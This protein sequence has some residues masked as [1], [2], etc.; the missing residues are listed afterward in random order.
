MTPRE[1]ISKARKDFV[2]THPFL[3]ELC[4]NLKVVE[5]TEL[6]STMGTDMACLYYN[7]EAV[8]A[9]DDMQLK[10]VIAHE[11]GH[12]VWR[13]AGKEG[14]ARMENKVHGVWSLACEY[15]ANNFVQDMC[16]LV[17]PKGAPYSS[18]YSNGKWTTE[19]IYHDILPHYKTI[20]VPAS[21]MDDHSMWG[22]G[23][24]SAAA[25]TES[26]WK[27]HVSRVFH[28]AK[29]KGKMPAGL[30]RIVEDVLEPE[31]PWRMVL[32]E[33]V[34]RTFKSDY[35]WRKPNKRHLWRKMVFPSIHSESIR[36]GYAQDT[37]GSMSNEELK[38]GYAE[39][40]GICIAFPSYEIH[41]F[42]CDAA[43]HSYQ[44]STPDKPVDLAELSKGGGGTD[45]RPV[46][47]Y[48]EEH[49]IDIDALVYFTDGEGTF[50]RNAPDYP[51]IWVI[52]GTANPPFGK[53]LRY[54]D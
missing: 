35:S 40:R 29:R 22:K 46:F 41:L 10:A 45:F 3:G 32:A 2:M 20:S 15:K 19:G 14:A 7:P 12:C 17:L 36:I 33:V 34:M 18:R 43:V 4:L 11:V 16:G 24:A 42:A 9:W 39:I 50:P 51:V 21:F 37:S 49:E 26:S 28:N 54:E 6:V 13:H 38:E 52:K 27:V 30:E 47:K 1:R 25:S 5:T 8:N 31:L 23:A 48:I 53:C 44:I